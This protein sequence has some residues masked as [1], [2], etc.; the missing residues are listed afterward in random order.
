MVRQMMPR[1]HRTF[2]AYLCLPALLIQFLSSGDGSVDY[3]EFVK[4]GEM[5]SEL[6]EMQQQAQADNQALAQQLTAISQA[7]DASPLPC[8]P[9]IILL[10]FGCDLGAISRF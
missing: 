9:M 2:S 10:L 1:Q 6:G 4:V 8:I 5:K 3:S 7:R